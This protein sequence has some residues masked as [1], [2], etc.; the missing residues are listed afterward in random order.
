MKRGPFPDRKVKAGHGPA[1]RRRGLKAIM[2][3]KKLLYTRMGM[4]GNEKSVLV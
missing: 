1:D 3:M 2:D 4:N